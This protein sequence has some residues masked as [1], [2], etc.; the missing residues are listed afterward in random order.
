MVPR[1]IAALGVAAAAAFGCSLASALENAP[2]NNSEDCLGDYTCTRTLSQDIAEPGLC[3]L[4]GA[5]APGLQAGCP[6]EPDADCDIGLNEFCSPDTGVCLCCAGSASADIFVG[7]AGDGVTPLCV[8][9][10]DDCEGD[11]EPCLAGSEGCEAGEG[12]C[13]CFRP[14]SA[15]EN[16][17][18]ID[19][20]S[21]GSSFQCVRTLEQEAES[22]ANEPEPSEQAE[23]DGVC[24]PIDDPTCLADR[25]IGCRS[26]NGCN[27]AVLLQERCTSTGNCYC[28]DISVFSRVYAEAQDGSSAACTECPGCMVGEVACTVLQNPSC[29]P[30]DGACGCMPE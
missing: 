2:C 10:P 17:S 11:Q 8:S 4:D 30:T 3:R 1:I 9:C 28:C 27:G 12:M 15:I 23:E 18:C 29:T 7:V 5:C 26:D 13:G 21:C 14:D 24:R 6:I 16:S 25:Q 20:E 22:A 19:D